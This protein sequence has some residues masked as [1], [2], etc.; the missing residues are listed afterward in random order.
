MVRGSLVPA[1]T[2]ATPFGHT[3]L[4]LRV[5]EPHGRVTFAVFPMFYFLFPK[6]G[7]HTY[8]F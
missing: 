1:R 7:D 8:A 5:T 4:R 2:F 3:H 6:Y